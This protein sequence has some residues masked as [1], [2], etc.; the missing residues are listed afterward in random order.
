MIFMIQ[1]T[2]GQLKKI[3][4]ATQYIQEVIRRAKNIDDA[5][6]VGRARAKNRNRSLRSRAYPDRP[7]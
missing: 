1:Q 6:A 2:F 7:K 3:S 5:Q 4:P